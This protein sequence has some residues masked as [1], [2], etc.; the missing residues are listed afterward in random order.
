MSFNLPKKLMGLVPV[1]LLG[2][3]G[4][5][6]PQLTSSSDLVL[7]VNGPLTAGTM[8]NAAST[9]S[10]PGIQVHLFNGS[11]LGLTS[12]A[13]GDIDVENGLEVVS[14]KAG[15]FGTATFRAYVPP[16]FAGLS[17]YLQ[18]IDDEGKKSQVHIETI[19]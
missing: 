17:V 10:T 13:Y 5:A 3:T 6:L 1:L 4:A 7:H 12:T 2:V 16:R 8:A 14:R 19:L 9:G 15:R 11:G 18:S